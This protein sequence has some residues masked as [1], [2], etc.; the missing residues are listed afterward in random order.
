M[1]PIS[2]ILSNNLSTRLIGMMCGAAVIVG[3]LV[4]TNSY[5][6]AA[7]M[8]E[9][10]AYSLMMSTAKGRQQAI[11][12]YLGSIKD[13]IKVLAA[14]P[15]A[16][17]A[18]ADFEI[19]WENLSKPSEKMRKLY[20]DE[21]PNK[22]GEK[23]KLNDAGD[24]SL[25]SQMHKKHHEWFTQLVETRAYYDIFIFNTKG[26]LI[27]TY[28]KEPDYGT[29]FKTGEYANT[30]LGK[31]YAKAMSGAPLS[32]HFEDF[33]PYAPS[34]NA[35]ASF[36]ASPIIGTNGE[37]VGVMALQM[38]VD[39]INKMMG[40]REGLG[41]TGETLLINEK[42]YL[43]A[44]APLSKSKDILETKI[45][46]DVI[47]KGF[48]NG[49]ATG[50]LHSY[51]NKTKLAS[52]DALEFNGAK[53]AV[54]SVKDL[55]E[56]Y[57]P[58]THMRNE[59]ILWS[60]IIIGLMAALGTWILRRSITQPMQETIQA[61]QK[62]ASGDTNI[63]IEELKKRTDE[64]GQMAQALVI[65]RE[66]IIEQKQITENE[67][68]S[69]AEREM[70]QQRIDNLIGGFRATIQEMLS[71][72]KDVSVR[73]S[74]TANQLSGI[75]VNA[76]QEAQSAS[77]ASAETSGNV[78]TVAAATEELAASIREIGQQVTQATSVV[79]SASEMA[80]N[81]DQQ[82]QQLDIAANKIGEIVS[83]IQS[84]AEQ[85]NLLALNATIEAARAGDAGRGFAVVAS[86]V[87]NLAVQTAKATDEIAQQINGIQSITRETVDAIRGIAGT[88]H[89]VER[90]TSAIAAA[91][92]EQNAATQEISRSVQNAAD[93]SMA[94]ASNIDSVSQAINETSQAAGMVLGV[95]QELNQNA[96]NMSEAVD[97]FLKNVAAA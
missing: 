55:D 40:E 62:L 88:M 95:V 69:V 77:G 51:L 39:I 9:E 66:A 20:I 89:D 27:Y 10:D 80:S 31:V 17:N 96:D 4:G 25:Y 2:K 38:P 72:V 82:V 50:E 79:G 32:V 16:R 90:Y 29:N 26:D 65:F 91:I 49:E 11:A 86:E 28:F 23:N 54:V 67:H 76:D 68:K 22:V 1:K 21:N 12:T 5:F 35:P 45:E 44:D 43:I 15:V 60:T 63:A 61:T 42:G 93:G 46:G 70:R 97:G 6:S 41:Q 8:T 18:L 58:F 30:G 73:M 33:E 3:T 81:A 24:G 48:K 59:I 71:S 36:I 78:Q 94:L 37:K 74:A 19:G 53:W 87:K 34:N 7:K 84:I 83:L 13:D 56:V 92:E 47:V 57:A 14:S 85:T 75:A 64:I 52:M